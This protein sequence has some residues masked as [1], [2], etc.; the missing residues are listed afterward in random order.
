[1]IIRKGSNEIAVV[2]EIQHALGIWVDGDFGPNTE[3]A[4]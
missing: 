4:I 2:K 3:D 1:M